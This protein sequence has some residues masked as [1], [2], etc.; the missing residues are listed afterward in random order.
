MKYLV[1]EKQ[2]RILSEQKKLGNFEL[3]N[4]SKLS[5]FT[6]FIAQNRSK[7]INAMGGNVTDATKKFNTMESLFVMLQNGEISAGELINGIPVENYITRQGGLRDDFVKFS[8]QPKTTNFASDVR[9]TNKGFK[10]LSEISDDDKFQLLSKLGYRDPQ[11]VIDTDV[12]WR[13]FG[14]D[15]DT[16]S[17]WKFHIYGEDLYDSVDLFERLEPLSNRWGFHAKVGVLVDFKPSSVQW[18]KG[19]VTIYIP[20]QVIKDNRTNDLLSDIES[21]LGGY[22][23][24]GKISGD[25]QITPSI[26]YRYELSE[27]INTS[28]GIDD[29][30]YR[31]LYNSNSGGPYK[32]DNVPDLFE[33]KPNRDISTSKVRLISG[34][35]WGSESL[36]QSSIDWSKV[37]NAKNIQDYNKIISDAIRTDNYSY[38]SR[39]GFEKFGITDFRDFLQN[40]IQPTG[41]QFN[42]EGKWSVIPK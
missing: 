37:T 39:G 11:A 10:T 42:I 4:F 9:S 30:K 22:K 41:K 34:Q 31:V 13:P 36:D 3:P 19:G 14:K 27:P 21:A 20:P 1:T 38:V 35:R 29:S 24:G 2:L 26:H 18:G 17:G 40:Q 28:V 5:D 32:P 23:K 8:N 25:K 6:K 12:K 33:V 15:P 7:F 16:M